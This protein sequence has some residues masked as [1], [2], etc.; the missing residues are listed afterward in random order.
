[1]KHAPLLDGEVV[2]ELIAD[3]SSAV[4]RKIRKRRKEL[5]FT[6][7]VVSELTGL[8]R[9]TIHRAEYDAATLR[10]EARHLLAAAL[11]VEVADLW[12]PIPLEQLRRRAVAL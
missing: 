11:V 7:N 10:D 6:L 8:S 1:M 4:G 2:E 9:Q 5:G 3:W 12:Q